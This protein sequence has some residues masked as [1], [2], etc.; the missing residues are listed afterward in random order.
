MSLQ[1]ITLVASHSNWRLFMIRKADPAF[2]KFAQK[3]FERDQHTCQYCGFCANNNLD[4]INR[5]SD[6]RNNKLSNLVTACSFC[7]QCFFLEAVGKGEFGGGVLVYLP[8]VSQSELNAMCHV[9]FTSMVVGNS[10]A[11]QAKNVY[12]GLRLQ[13]Q[14]IE[15]QVGEGFSNPFLYGRLLIEIEG[16]QSRK[17]HNQLLPH[18]RLLPDI[19]RFAMQVKDWVQ[20]SITWLEKT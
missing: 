7:A 12:R 11:I 14:A 17:L 9:L 3:V 10:Y 6:Y 16:E 15:K 4:V 13:S 20:D 18:I 2:Q 19:N 8:N 5:D 1:N